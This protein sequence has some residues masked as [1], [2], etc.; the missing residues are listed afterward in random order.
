MIMLGPNAEAL[1]HTRDWISWES[2]NA[3]ALNKDVWVL[4]LL[5][6]SPKVSVVIPYLR[7]Y[8]KRT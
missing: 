2:G 8:I 6:D 4:E 3:A 7:H 5:E 1:K